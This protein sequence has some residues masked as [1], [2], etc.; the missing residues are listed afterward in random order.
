MDSMQ[1]YK[2][3]LHKTYQSYYIMT[4]IYISY[5][6]TVKIPETHTL[7]TSLAYNIMWW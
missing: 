4:D 6:K 7:S 2:T 1:Y 3:Q 5:P